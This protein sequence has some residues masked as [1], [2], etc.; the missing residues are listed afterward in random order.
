MLHGFGGSTTRAGGIV[1]RGHDGHHDSVAK[2]RRRP[3][4]RT[5]LCRPASDRPLYGRG[6]CHRRP[7]H[8][9]AVVFAAAIGIHPAAAPEYRAG[10]GGAGGF[11]NGGS[12]AI[13]RQL[14]LRSLA[15]QLADAVAAALALHYGFA[16]VPGSGAG[17][18][19]GRGFKKDFWKRN[20]SAKT[21]KSAR[22]NADGTLAM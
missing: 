6:R 9:A 19:T 5:E 2:R 21:A 7:Q 14:R 16:K 17:R 8:H 10:G 22:V 1:C 20:V 18:R 13:R 4:H 11:F 12:N 3:C 15:E